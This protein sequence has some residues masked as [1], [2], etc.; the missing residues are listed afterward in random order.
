MFSALS[1]PLLEKMSF[2]CGGTWGHVTKCPPSLREFP[3]KEHSTVNLQSCRLLI[4]ACCRWS[5]ENG[6]LLIHS[7]GFNLSIIGEDMKIKKEI[8]EGA[9]IRSSPVRQ[10]DVGAV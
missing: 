1:T 2:I 10:S 3:H 7:L 4:T 6:A 9:R 5:A 8:K